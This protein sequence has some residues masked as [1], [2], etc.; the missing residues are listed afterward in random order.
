MG[1]HS[2]EQ[3]FLHR[4]LQ[5]PCL[6]LRLDPLGKRV[7]N[8]GVGHVLGKFAETEKEAVQNAVE[9][10]GNAA[11]VLVTEGLDAAMNRFN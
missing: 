8:D 7:P 2:D 9:H 1:I 10:V 6:D 11:E 4:H 3:V 5:V